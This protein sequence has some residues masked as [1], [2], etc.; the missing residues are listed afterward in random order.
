MD[1]RVRDLDQIQE[2]D[3]NDRGRRIGAILMAT[4]SIVGLTFAVGVL[5]G[6]A[7]EP[8]APSDD[9]LSKLERSAATGP[10][11]TT[12][13]QE[14]ALPRV[15]AADMSFPAT[16]G[17]TDERPEVLDALKA[18]AAEEAALAR[19]DSP[20]QEQ[21]ALPSPAATSLQNGEPALP[22]DAEPQNAAAPQHFATTIPAAVAAGTGARSLPQVV[23]HDRLVADA[24]RGDAV[25]ISAPHGHDGEYTLQVISY[26][27]PEPS[28]A[29]AEA[30]RQKGHAAFVASAD[31]PDRGRYYRVRIGPFK[32]REQ[33]E[34]YRHK[35]ED[36]E[37]MN[38]F[39]VR[40][41]PDE[42]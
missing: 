31:V 42:S 40:N 19:A 15:D 26:E 16:L 18:A 25:L 11:R 32:N 35:F 20:A 24:M 33:A 39:V 12:R 8:V 23:K 38:T 9:P 2:R 27:R 17:E 36:D 37:H 13:T 30:L 22:T 28:R 10:S 5:V 6:R 21:A 14:V 1:H 29:F 4:A 3:N 41:V 7:A 34:T